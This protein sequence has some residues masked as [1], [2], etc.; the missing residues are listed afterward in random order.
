MLGEALVEMTTLTQEDVTVLELDNFYREI[1]EVYEIQGIDPNSE[2][3]KLQ[4][5]WDDPNL[6]DYEKLIDALK[7]LKETGKTTVG[8]YDKDSGTYPGNKTKTYRAKKII[9]I[10]SFILFS[11]NVPIEGKYSS[12]KEIKPV[13][14]NSEEVAQELIDLV[15]YKISVTCDALEAW[16]RRIIRDTQETN[17]DITVTDTYWHRDAMPGAERFIYPILHASEEENIFD[18]SIRNTIFREVDIDNAFCGIVD[19]AKE[20]EKNVWIL[21][22]YSNSKSRMNW[23]GDNYEPLVIKQ[24]EQSYRTFRAENGT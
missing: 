7:E 4:I 8:V 23:F 20:K 15:D 17:R 10:E 5:N 6:L 11:G 13:I 18:I 14:E 2:N 1:D 24:A 22:R 12:G 19:N 21:N 9:L 16:R 3:P